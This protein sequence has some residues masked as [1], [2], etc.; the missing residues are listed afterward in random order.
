MVPR[1]REG[2]FSVIEV[3]L[4]MGVFAFV[5]LSLMGS[6]ASAY[7]LSM[8]NRDRATA[9]KEAQ[10]VVNNIRAA[11]D[12]GIAVPDGVVAQFPAGPLNP[13]RAALPLQVTTIAYT[14]PA[15][16]PL[17]VTVTVQWSTDSGRTLREQ[18]TA[19]VAP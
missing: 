13:P 10:A 2:G 17:T 16:S 5:F 11:R 14:D 15:A 3:I 19:L 8:E 12:Q 7:V 9:V 18:L 4:A 6:V 1:K